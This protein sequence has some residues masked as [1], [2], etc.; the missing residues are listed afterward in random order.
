MDGNIN[1]SRNTIPRNAE[2]HRFAVLCIS[3][4]LR[5]ASRPSSSQLG[6]VLQCWTHITQGTVSTRDFILGGACASEL[7]FQLTLHPIPARVVPR[8]AAPLPRLSPCAPPTPPAP[9]LHYSLPAFFIPCCAAISIKLYSC[10][11]CAVYSVVLA[12]DQWNFIIIVIQRLS[13]AQLLGR[14]ACNEIENLVD[15][16]GHDSLTINAPFHPGFTVSPWRPRL[17]YRP[18]GVKTRYIPVYTSFSIGLPSPRK[19]PAVHRPPPPPEVDV[20]AELDVACEAEEEAAEGGRSTESNSE[21]SLFAGDRRD[22]GS[23]DTVV[24]DIGVG[25]IADVEAGVGGTR[26]LA[27]GAPALVDLSARSAL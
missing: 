8:M 3:C 20:D 26:V 17:E 16:C 21:R 4:H 11:P 1:T 10:T 23:L 2:L 15:F 25:V 22:Q 6:A 27:E 24:G 18:P 13:F 7:H 12:P 5:A 19:R 14:A 9:A